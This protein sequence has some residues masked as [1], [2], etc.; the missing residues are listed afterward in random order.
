M[1][2]K[3]CKT[4]GRSSLE[5]NLCF[6]FLYN[7]FPKLFLNTLS[8]LCLMF[9]EILVC[10]SA[11]CIL[12]F[13]LI[14]MTEVSWKIFMAAIPLRLLLNKL[15]LFDKCRSTNLVELVILSQDSF[16]SHRF[17]FNGWLVRKLNF[18][19]SSSDA[20][21]P[22]KIASFMRNRMGIE[23][24]LWKPCV[25]HIPQAVDNIQCSIGVIN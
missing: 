19:V 20:N 11:K 13:R 14:L 17:M 23:Q 24:T 22:K 25:S 12:V 9:A 7:F 1:Y 18:K 5:W 10:L 15:H 8:G 4:Y 3:N 2:I 21:V 16:R 6:I